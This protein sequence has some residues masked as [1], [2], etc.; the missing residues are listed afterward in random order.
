MKTVVVLLHCEQTNVDELDATKVERYIYF[1]NSLHNRCTDVVTIANDGFT[2]SLN[3]GRNFLFVNDI[4]INIQTYLNGYLCGSGTECVVIFILDALAPSFRYVTNLPM[5]QFHPMFLFTKTINYNSVPFLTH[6]FGEIVLGTFENIDNFFKQYDE[7]LTL[8]L[9]SISAT[10]KILI[11]MCTTS[12]LQITSTCPT[13]HTDFHDARQLDRLLTWLK[14][15]DFES[16]YEMLK[17]LLLR[18]PSYIR[19]YCIALIQ[20]TEMSEI[21]I[22]DKNSSETIPLWHT[23]NEDIK[24]RIV[25]YSDEHCRRPLESVLTK[26]QDTDKFDI[27]FVAECNFVYY[28]YEIVSNLKTIEPQVLTIWHSDHEMQCFYLKYGCGI[29]DGIDDKRFMFMASKECISSTLNNK[30]VNK[31]HTKFQIT[32]VS[33]IKSWNNYQ[34]TIQPNSFTITKKCENIDF[35]THQPPNILQALFE[36]VI[37]SQPINPLPLDTM[38]VTKP[39]AKKGDFIKN[40]NISRGKSLAQSGLVGSI[41]RG[42]C[43][44]GASSQFAFGASAELPPQI[45]GC[46]TPFLFGLGTDK[47][48]KFG[49]QSLA[50]PKISAFKSSL[51]ETPEIFYDQSY[52][53]QA[54]ISPRGDVFHLSDWTQTKLKFDSNVCIICFEETVDWI[55][56]PCNH[57]VTCDDDYKTTFINNPI[58]T[59]PYCRTVGTL[60]PRKTVFCENSVIRIPRQG[61]QQ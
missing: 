50:V 40:R 37:A 5:V 32:S 30:P 59:C 6:S 39:G 8:P 53:L 56:V 38:M 52:H 4:N 60:Q 41:S 18:P 22:L 27:T 1:N 58:K 26:C 46:Q 29:V 43:G 54:S 49:T 12:R 13:S 16:K 23:Y 44:S 2:A 19:N 25:G 9:R 34:L 3:E 47:E 11:P 55:F 45:F 51:Y 57:G 20:E 14:V 28:T 42:S 24:F 48:I 17:F 7:I 31:M 35:K 10:E 33:A 21:N 15:L 61:Y 36:C